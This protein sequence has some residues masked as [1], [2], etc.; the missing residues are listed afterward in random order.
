M[1]F[2]GIAPAMLSLLTDLVLTSSGE[3]PVNLIYFCVKIF[4]LASSKKINQEM[5]TE[6]FSLRIYL[7]VTL[8]TFD[9]GM[10]ENVAQ[11]HAAELTAQS[12]PIPCLT[13]FAVRQ[14]HAQLT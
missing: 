12:A 7:S 3:S 6:K 1:Y 5:H 4:K 9:V 10:V 13:S 8:L 11:R 14:T 2:A